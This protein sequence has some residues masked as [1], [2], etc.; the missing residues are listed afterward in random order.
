VFRLGVLSWMLILDP[1][2]QGGDADSKATHGQPCSEREEWHTGSYHTIV[3]LQYA[4][5]LIRESMLP[6]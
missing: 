3:V 2:S 4:D 6:R 1:C 5:F